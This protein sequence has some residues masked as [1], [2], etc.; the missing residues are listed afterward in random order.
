MH[1]AVSAATTNRMARGLPCGAVRK[2]YFEV[3]RHG[4]L[5]QEYLTYE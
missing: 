2:K 1:R 3:P 5:D 4:G